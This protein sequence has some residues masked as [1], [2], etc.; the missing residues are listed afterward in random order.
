M[1]YA[2]TS[3]TARFKNCKFYGVSATITGTS[4][5]MGEMDGC[6]FGDAITY[7][8]V[9]WEDGSTATYY[10]TTE[11]INK[12][13]IDKHPN[14]K[15]AYA[16]KSGNKLFYVTAPTA[17]ISYD[18]AMNATV[19]KTG[20]GTEIAFTY[21]VN[22]GVTQYV[23]SLGS[24]EADGENFHTLLNDK[25]NV[26]IKM[27]AD[28]VLTKGVLFGTLTEGKDQSGYQRWTHAQSGNVD[29]DLNG[30][31]VTM[32]EGATPFTIEPADKNYQA[33]SVLHWINGGT[34]KLYSSVPNGKY[35]N[36]SAYSIFGTD[37]SQYY[38]SYL[39]GT[40]DINVNGGDNL[41][42]I[43]KGS[44]FK[45]YE[46]SSGSD[47]PLKAYLYING[48][49]YIYSGTS[50]LACFGGQ[51]V[52]KNATIITEGAAKTVFLNHYWQTANL[53]VDNVTVVAKDDATLLAASG[54]VSDLL[55]NDLHNAHKITLSNLTLIGKGLK[56]VYNVTTPANKLTYTVNGVVASDASVLAT[57]YPT[58]PDGKTLAY[59]YI[60]VNGETALVMG[61]A[62]DSEAV[63]V[64]NT[65]I[66]RTEKWLVGEKY[67]FVETAD[68]ISSSI[69]KVDGKWQ[70]YTNPTWA[71]TLDGNAIDM[72]AICGAANAGKTV[73]IAITGDSLHPLAFT[74]QITGGELQFV[75]SLG[76]PEADGENFVAL[77]GDKSNVKIVMYTDI[78]L[79]EG[80][81]FG[82][83]VDTVDGTANKNPTKKPAYVKDPKY[84]GDG[85]Y[86]NVD[87]DLN[88]CTVT[89]AADA[90]P[91]SMVAWLESQGPQTTNVLHYPGYVNFKLYSSVE[92]GEY[93]NLS[94][95]PIFGLNK[96]AVGSYLLGTSDLNVDG[97]D[98]LTIVSNAALTAAYETNESGPSG[99]V[100]YVNGGT[101]VYTGGG[102]LFSVGHNAYIYNAKL[103]ATGA[104]T[105][106][107]INHFWSTTTLK[108]KN[109]DM[110]AKNSA[111]QFIRSGTYA[112]SF[113]GNG[114]KHTVSIE[115][116]SF[117]GGTMNVTY[118]V[119]GA[120]YASCQVSMN[121]AG[122][123]KAPNAAGLA[124]VYPEAPEG[125]T[126]AY[127]TLTI[128][129]ET[130]KVLG[131]Y[132]NPAIVTVKND[133]IDLT[134][135]WLVGE[136]YYTVD[137]SA[138]FMQMIDG[139][140][141]YFANPAWSAK[142]G[143]TVV[144]F[145][146]ICSPENAGKTVVVAIDGEKDVLYFT[147]LHNGE[148]TYYCGDTAIAQLKTLLIPKNSLT[149]EFCFYHDIEVSSGSNSYAL[150]YKSDSKAGEAPNDATIK[151]DLNG[152]TW[153]VNSTS[154][155]A[156]IV[157][158]ATT[159]I[160][161]SVPGG[162]LDVSQASGIACTDNAADA[163]FGEATKSGT[164]Y[165]KNFTVYC[166]SVHSGRWWSNNGY[167]VG[168][169]YIQPEGVTASHFFGIDDGSAPTVRNST[170][171]V[172]SLSDGFVRGVKGTFTNCVFIAKE[173]SNIVV[174]TS[175][176]VGATFNGCY[177]YNAIPNTVAGVTVTYIN[178]N[179]SHSSTI[180]QA[181]GYIAY[182]GEPVTLKVN[183]VDY[184]FGAQ[185]VAEATLVDWGFGIQ[186]Y[187]VNGATASHEST[188][189]DGLFAYSFNTFVV[190]EGAAEAT[191]ISIKPGTMQMTL[192]LK[193][194]IGLNMFFAEVLKGATITVN[195]EEIAL[196]EA[197]D[198]YYKFIKTIAPTAAD[199][200]VTIVIKIG[201]NVHEI[202][203][204]IEKYA[205][206]ILADTEGAYSI[207]AKYLTY[208]M[209]EYVR[210]MTSDAFCKGVAVPAEYMVHETFEVPYEKND[211][212]KLLTNIAF[213]L[214][215]TIAIAV[216][217]TA[218]AE[219]MEVNLL[220]GTGRSER[221]TIENGTA[222]FSGIYVN[223]FLGT[224]TIKVGGETYYYCLENY[225]AAEEAS[226]YVDVIR[227]LY[228][229]A[230]YADLYVE[231]L[232]QEN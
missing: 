22:G 32:A 57:A 80:V 47:T 108:I 100:L 121:F 183:G 37:K 159:F 29:W 3:A 55:T 157:S 226:A 232:P 218:D 18:D 222:I 82:E 214:D 122:E 6:T 93:I 211:G 213:Q 20:K 84:G 90:K 68:P 46:L 220:L 10:P 110:V 60:K 15:M 228:N 145:K 117:A 72:D 216:K 217:G 123:F 203:A 99:Y 104:P 169:T 221:V 196:G 147:M 190:G 2:T 111:T 85:S 197:K 179:F 188:V 130:V 86:G 182:T 75:E 153:K 58:A 24:P 141:Y 64:Q 21:S 71:A 154:S 25:T 212:N 128:Y 177:F 127:S 89:V 186:E 184:V 103:V 126:A 52:I 118:A 167:I 13:F 69:V 187:W 63:T 170:F 33:F 223:E 189:V 124:L 114:K 35:V 11:E 133:T 138:F 31:T 198:G 49:T 26:V 9:T 107:I 137:A 43:T 39:V 16:V 191:L 7:K 208:A 134:E 178:C 207:E 171:I 12:N 149:Y 88:G 229:Y 53:A 66:G 219:G 162:V 155:Y 180:P 206:T 98:N 42:V 125:K 1:L 87:W 176:N 205:Q 41:S 146:N 45:G 160:Y 150:G 143:D 48:G 102:T 144:D 40:N 34:F 54:G 131:Y 166:K 73:T 19:T 8:T 181:G 113:S 36:N 79:K 140:W 142:V 129:G 94:S 148:T 61:Y 70:Y 91:I 28:I 231:T 74:Y 119:Y 116:A 83:L 156:F 200:A 135:V 27:Y 193:G 96:Y 67:F 139:I 225:L 163:Y 38:H 17:V 62:A 65:T 174:N 168:G 195:G 30:H 192:T 224:M 81:R 56:P 175:N 164:E 51:N 161:S 23:A 185:L 77:F 227:A 120:N 173:A 158:D 59:A 76:T 152:Y 95:Y 92:G 132:E 204:G 165:G 109:V 201:E 14:T 230:S 202:S 136:T 106:M 194:H 101:Y 199:D 97:G 210:T 172:N 209:V 115:N 105:A 112:G 151:I 4:G 215:G 44:L 5:K 50:A 78:L